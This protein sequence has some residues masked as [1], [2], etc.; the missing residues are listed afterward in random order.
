[1][2]A[3][4]AHPSLLNDLA[5][6]EFP[7]PLHFLDEARE[8]CILVLCARMS[9]MSGKPDGP[10]LH[11]LIRRFL[12]S[13]PVGDGDLWSW[14][15][16]CIGGSFNRKSYDLWLK[17]ADRWR[18]EGIRVAEPAVPVRGVLDSS[19]ASSASRGALTS[20]PGEEIQ[21]VKWVGCGPVR[22]TPGPDFAPVVPRRG[23]P[24]PPGAESL[25]GAAKATPV[26]G[27]DFG[28][29][30][31]VGECGP[32]AGARGQSPCP[33]VLFTKGD[34]PDGMPWIAVFN[35]RKPKSISPE[36]SWL[37]ALR[38]ALG[39]IPS[40]GIAVAGSTGTLTYDLVTAH[41]MREGLPSAVVTPFP[42]LRSSP[43]GTD[44]PLFAGSAAI[45]CLLTT[46]SCSGAMR[47]L[48][49]D[50]LLAS[51]S[52]AHLVIELRRGGNLMAIIEDAQTAC[53]KPLYIFD[54][55]G[56]TPRNAGNYQ[57]LEK[58]PAWSR[59]FRITGPVCRAEAGTEIPGEKPVA[60]NE[61]GLTQSDY[62]VDSRENTSSSHENRSEQP[63]IIDWGEFLFHYTRACPGPW[64]G[65]PRREYL[66]GL[67][68]ADSLSA[69]TAL[70]TL[71]RILLECRIRSGN[72]LIRGAEAVV[73]WSSHPP[74]N[75]R[76]LR[77]WNS[78][79]A[80]WTIEPYGIAVSR[81][82]LRDVGVKPAIYG[83]DR[84]HDALP[85]PEKFRFQLSNDG[86]GAWRDEREWRSRGDFEIDRVPGGK[87]F[88]FV[89]SFAE[90]E[91]LL[92][93]TGADIPVIVFE[94]TLSPSGDVP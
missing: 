8:Y 82:L 80:R 22:H 16:E 37:K 13:Q 57:L 89:P 1:M 31:P 77:K 40:G 29:A 73:C 92:G 90:R 18:E 78:S 38:F 91:K 49:R 28:A 4:D 34:I 72:K 68:D 65:Q 75:Y 86:R 33:A 81:S 25:S 15:R 51:I 69:H 14:M 23:L 7:S 2:T 66:L 17:D 30:D 3:K 44:D 79:L 47:L 76:I 60:A 6:K 74:C 62:P 20:S 55:G 70:D 52:H 24:P 83:R 10:A 42:I 21:N 9:R 41:A 59:K 56:I 85:L 46:N 19:R 94:E 39:E 54:P 84:V 32:G 11:D 36:S 63:G 58:F 50:R 45:S 71:V 12:S 88:A 35:S 53:A 87:W 61:Y 5:E 93:R 26:S 27:R 64:P 43:E 67:L 48:C